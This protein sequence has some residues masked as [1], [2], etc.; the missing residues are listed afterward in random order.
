MMKFGS[1]SPVKEAIASANTTVGV[2][3]S[4]RGTL[5]V[6]GTLRIDGELTD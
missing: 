4:C 3:S 1:R 2:G 6:S 5:M